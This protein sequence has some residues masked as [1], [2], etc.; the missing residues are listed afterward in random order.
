MK[1]TLLKTLDPFILP[2]G[3]RDQLSIMRRDLNP[4]L[5]PERAAQET[6][7]AQPS[8][9]RTPDSG[10]LIPDAD[11]GDIVRSQG[12]L[13]GKIRRE[14]GFSDETFRDIITPVLIRAA[15]CTGLL[16]SGD[17]LHHTGQGGLFRFALEG[18]FLTARLLR[19]Y[20]FSQTADPGERAEEQRRFTAA[21][22][23][24]SLAGALQSL[25]SKTSVESADGALCWDPFALPLHE[26]CLKNGLREYRASFPSVCRSD[27][28]EAAEGLMSFVLTPAAEGYLSSCG[29][30]LPS[31]IPG[32]SSRREPSDGAEPLIRKAAAEASRFAV[33]KD[34]VLSGGG[35]DQTGTI[36]DSMKF[37]ALVAEFAG[38]RGVNR[39]G[40]RLWILRRKDDREPAAFLSF[41][42]LFETASAMIR[43]GALPAGWCGKDE[44]DL[45]AR[46]LQKGLVRQ[47]GDGAVIYA[48][49]SVLRGYGVRLRMVE[50]TELPQGTGNTEPLDADFPEVRSRDEGAEGTADAQGEEAGDE[51]S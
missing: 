45:A 19:G 39:N 21:G 12:V 16:P 44:D 46:L 27:G 22:M 38:S 11:P 31:A 30:S 42:G 23:F 34:T 32:I 3:E 20:V 41:A 49:P 14:A 43:S 28:A 36:P 35:A 13:L 48:V 6:G 26:W 15:S 25:T 17:P 47:Q 4:A 9:R 18:A 50:L 51:A 1:L 29:F 10:G 37:A 7:D 2:T 8:G 33:L 40:A 5:I 24:A